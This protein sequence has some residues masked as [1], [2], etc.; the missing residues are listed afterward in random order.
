M[1]L[2][3]NDR[4]DARHYSLAYLQT[5]LLTPRPGIDSFSR[6]RKLEVNNWLNDG[7]NICFN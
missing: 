5:E 4:L 1:P 2:S 3:I 7:N 6:L